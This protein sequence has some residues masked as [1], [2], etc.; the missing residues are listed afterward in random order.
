M[1]KLILGG[2]VCVAAVAAILMSIQEQRIR[3]ASE[4]A[5]EKL[6]EVIA[7]GGKQTVFWLTAALGFLV[8][9]QYWDRAK[10]LEKY[11]G[12]APADLA[13]EPYVEEGLEMVGEFGILF[14]LLTLRLMQRV[15]I[16]SAGPGA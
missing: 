4:A 10:S 16:P 9:S 11:I 13:D 8:A 14:L 12:W 7:S 2:V 5:H 1:G 15:R 6:E 3:L